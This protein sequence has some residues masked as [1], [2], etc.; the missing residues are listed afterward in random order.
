MSITFSPQSLGF[1]GFI[2]LVI[3]RCHIIPNVRIVRLE[4]RDRDNQHELR[5]RRNEGLLLFLELAH[6]KYRWPGCTAYDSYK[7]RQSLH[8]ARDSQQDSSLQRYRN[9]SEKDYV[10]VNS[11]QLSGLP[12]FASTISFS[13]IRATPSLTR[14]RSSRG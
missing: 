3:A 11:D 7:Q 13:P 10:S 5:E 14:N 4:C 8:A 2:N 12:T 6:P 9:E 1:V